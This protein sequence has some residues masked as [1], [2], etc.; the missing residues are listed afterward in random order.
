M[1]SAEAL[2]HVS[3]CT[4]TFSS[5]DSLMTHYSL[6]SDSLLLLLVMPRHAALTSAVDFL[7]GIV[8]QAEKNEVSA[9]L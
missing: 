9:V 8:L 7:H 5:D 6:L 2:K 4:N 1:E 3:V